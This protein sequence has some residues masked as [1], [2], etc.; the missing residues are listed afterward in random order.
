MSEG[1]NRDAELLARCKY[2]LDNDHLD[3][4]SHKSHQR[5]P[6]PVF[7]PTPRLNKS[8]SDQYTPPRPASARAQ[9][10][11]AAAA[12]A[13]QWEMRKAAKEAEAA[14]AGRQRGEQGVMAPQLRSSS[15]F[16]ASENLSEMDTEFKRLLMDGEEHAW[17]HLDTKF[18][19]LQ[20]GPV[21]RRRL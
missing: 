11:L 16:M 8:S 7:P 13:D 5:F 19:P 14:E 20:D 2:L 21:D 4:L 9:I 17:E 18:R 15:K 3:D 12:A 6:A 1:E 10:K